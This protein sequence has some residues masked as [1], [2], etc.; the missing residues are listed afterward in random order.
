MQTDL[1]TKTLHS[2]SGLADSKARGARHSADERRTDARHLERPRPRRRHDRDRRWQARYISLD[3]RGERGTHP[4][5]GKWSRSTLFPLPRGRSFPPQQNGRHA[6]APLELRASARF[7]FHGARDILVRQRRAEFQGAGKLGCGRSAPP[8][9]DQEGTD[10]LRCGQGA[11][12]I[13]P[14]LRITS[15]GAAL[16][17][18]PPWP[19]RVD[20]RHSA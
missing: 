13:P 9:I 20:T 6:P 5:W 14:P 7:V 11:D 4:L 12:A 19:H 10:G 17:T 2:R 3:V 8:N 18:H 16:K 15:P 1:L